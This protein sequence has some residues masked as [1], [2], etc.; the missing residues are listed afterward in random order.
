MG[1]TEYKRTTTQAAARQAAELTDV[2]TQPEPPTATSSRRSIP[3]N[4]KEVVYVTRPF[5]PLAYE[6]R[7]Y[8]PGDLATTSFPKQDRPTH[9]PKKAEESLP[10][11]DDTAEEQKRVLTQRELARR[12]RTRQEAK[13]TGAKQLR[14]AFS[15]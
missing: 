8:I 1:T 11:K 2:I 10:V 4:I 12:V 7:G 13:P 14:T 3:C 15:Y 9:R 6:V 5:R